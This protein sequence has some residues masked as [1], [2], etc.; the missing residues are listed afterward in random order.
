MKVQNNPKRSEIFKM[1]SLILADTTFENIVQELPMGMCEMAREFRAFARSRSVRSP[2]ELLRAVLLYCGLDYTLREVAANFT[3]VGRRLSDE[4]VRGRLSACIPWLGAMLQEMLPKP[5]Q[6]IVQYAHRLILV[7]ATCIQAP[8]AK[9][10]D[11]RLHLAWDWMTQ[12][13][14]SI[15]I[16]DNHTGE[17]LTLYEWRAGD[18]VLA[19]SGYARAPQLKA[20]TE[21]GA[22][23]VVRC[24]PTC[25]RMLLKTGEKL[26][27]AEEL[28]KGEDAASVTIPV[29]INA[30]EASQEAYLHAFRLTESAAKEARR[31]MR[32]RSSKR[33]RP[34]PKPNTLYLAGWTLLLTSFKPEQVSAE[35]IGKV[36]RARWQIELVIKR[37]KSVL[38]LDALRARR[39]S[40][41]AQV[42]LLGKSLYALMIETRA[43]KIS[44]TREVEW[45]LWRIVADQIRAWITL[46]EIL[47]PNINRD[48]IK[49]L[50]ER[51]RKRQRLRTKMAEIVH[52][53]G[54][55]S[56]H[57]NDLCP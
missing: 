52:K 54:L 23:F 32:R 35:S 12:R 25:V 51:P 17:S 29:M 16:T 37:L 47:D 33:G 46:A 45:R 36:Y 49:V 40:R 13:V 26:N 10:S 11:Y 7:D 53:L 22:E 38:N 8:G 14:V 21:R 55:K 5:D 6:G 27:I 43:L 41:L 9:S 4:A 56:I 24:P 18:V 42:Y 44:R 3:Q 28:R 31:K 20:V 57:I 30:K 34:M 1:P 48:V 50:K 39:G 2:E 15:V 19:D